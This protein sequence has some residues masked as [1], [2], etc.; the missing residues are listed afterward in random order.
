MR[1]AVAAGLHHEAL[2]LAERAVD[3][4]GRH[5]DDVDLAEA[6]M[7]VARA[8]LLAGDVE[9]AAAASGDATALFEAQDRAGWWAAA[10]T[11]RVDARRR[12]GVADA[13][14]VARIDAVIAAT[15]TAGLGPATAEARIVAAELAPVLGDAAAADRY[16]DAPTAAALGAGRPVPPC[17]RRTP[18]WPA[19]PAIADALRS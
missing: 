12:A 18:G 15:E 14:D 1:G 11:L 2:A 5:G 3:E 9:R 19:A 8:A 17:A 13:T 7:L 10:A 4:P 16:A 6:L